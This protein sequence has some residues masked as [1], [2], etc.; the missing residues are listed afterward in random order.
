[1]TISYRQYQLLLD[2]SASRLGSE[3]HCPIRLRRICR[4]LG[5]HGIRR[6]RLEGAK[7]LL[8]DAK[9][10]PVIILN[11]SVGGTG[12][13]EERFTRLE[14]FLIAHELGHLV[15]HQR[16]MKNPSGPSEYWKVEKLCDAFA[17]RLLVP[18]GLV[19]NLIDQTKPTALGRLTTTL[20]VARQCSV[21][22]SAAAQRITEL[23][24]DTV[25]FRLAR[26]P[27]R[28]F[29]I[30]VSTHPGNQ[31]IGQLIKPGSS[32]CETLG[33]NCKMHGPHEIAADK[34][35]GIGGVTGVRSA[36]L[37]AGC[38]AVMSENK[39]GNSL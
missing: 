14:R 2:E 39:F 22:W 28:G 13:Q 27:P 36:A 23:M 30:I 18:E 29:K 5:V 11:T 6:D 24:N 32:L 21:H 3:S 4:E 31:G 17:R 25:F 20:K 15:L 35:E 12:T 10:K 7:S 34:L 26:I 37:F 9:A 1:M 19:A 38:L 8:V 16:G 33:K